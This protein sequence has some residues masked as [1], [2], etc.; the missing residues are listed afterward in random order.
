MKIVVFPG[1]GFNSNKN[2][3]T[4]FCKNIVQKLS[5]KGIDCE[6]EFFYWEHNW[7]LL[8]VNL[9]Y[10][11]LRRWLAEIILDFQQVSKYAF[12][13]KVP[14]ADYYMGYSAGSVLAI[15]QE[16]K[17]CIILG[18]PTVMVESVKP[19]N[20]ESFSKRFQKAI[21]YDNR[22]I[23]NIINK[24]DQLAFPINGHNNIEN[25][26]YKTNW[27]R[28]HT[29]NPIAAHVNYWNHSNVINKISNT[30]SKWHNIFV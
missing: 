18:S 15:A 14:D 12:E 17:S 27:L 8:D 21:D 20:Q 10:K 3:H 16:S 30:I 2:E 1:V 5:Q 13:M 9:P 11:K 29:Y 28:P 6:M 25:Y 23:L 7:T 19:K 4:S 22:F 26:I 24:Y